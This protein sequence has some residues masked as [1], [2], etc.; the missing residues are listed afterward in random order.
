MHEGDP[1][2]AFVGK[3]PL[4]MH[5][6]DPLIFDGLPRPKRTPKSEI[7]DPNCLGQV[8]HRKQTLAQKH[9]M[10][11]AL[12]EGGRRAL[13]RSVRS[14]QAAVRWGSGAAVPLVVNRSQRSIRGFVFVFW[15]GRML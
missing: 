2:I 9:G 10:W 3:R 14:S 4:P 7:S 1:L 13:P 15:E 12:V 8:P 11:I 6:G 5:E